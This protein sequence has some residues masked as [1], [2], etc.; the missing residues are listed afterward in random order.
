MDARTQNNKEK[1]KMRQFRGKFTL[2][3]LLVVIAIIAILAALLLPALNSAKDKVRTVSCKSNQRQLGYCLLNYAGDNKEWGPYT[4]VNTT[5]VQYMYYW[6]MGLEDYIPYSKVPGVTGRAGSRFYKL[7]VCPGDL[8]KSGQAI[9][10]PGY[11]DQR[12]YSS[13]NLVFGIAS[14]TSMDGWYGWIPNYPVP[15]GMKKLYPCPS[16]NFCGKGTTRDGK[17]GKSGTVQQP[18]LQP[19]LADR[20][21]LLGYMPSLEKIRPLAHKKAMNILFA[22]GHVGY[23]SGKGGEYDMPLHENN[24]IRF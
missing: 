16:L 12:I 19:L 23:W 13:Y 7:A 21:S 14:R 8:Y 4:K 2:I 1:K 20:Y 17:T 15:A 6:S 22:D 18:S 10:Y 11:Y 3:E 5:H 9:K 24:R